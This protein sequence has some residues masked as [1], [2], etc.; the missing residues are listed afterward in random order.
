MKRKLN[1]LIDELRRLK[2]GGVEAV[3]VSDD[4][5][6]ALRNRIGTTK[7]PPSGRS[8]IRIRGDEEAV[9]ELTSALKEQEPVQRASTKSKKPKLPPPPK[10]ELPEGD[11]QSRWEALR[12][13]V[14]SDPICIGSEEPGRK[15]VFGSGNLD[16]DI[17][18]INNEPGL[19]EEEADR[20]IAGE[21]GDL[22]SK[23]IA[24]MGIESGDVYIANIM[25]W[26]PPVPKDVR[27]R[28]PT[29]E[30]I[31]YCRPYLEAQIDLVKPKVLVALGNRVIHALLGGDS[32]R[33]QEV[34]GNWKE[35]LGTPVMLTYHPAYLV[36]RNRNEDKRLVWEDLLKVM[37][38]VGLP[39]SER[40][41]RYFLPKR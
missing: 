12:E 40:Q 29:P 21:A 20:P 36:R 37:E 17:F 24:A 41:R 26:R 35:F 2:E 30:E 1:L 10:I 22:L 25:N 33:L 23:I 6:A 34:R 28:E 32:K 11:K 38:K 13:Q 14:L 19:E 5:L 7:M 27:K 15:V 3:Y 16:A 18:F 4:A 31:G 9:R 8:R 39:I